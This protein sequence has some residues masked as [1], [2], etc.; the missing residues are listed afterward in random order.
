EGG[1]RA[2]V[3]PL[4]VGNEEMMLAAL[5]SQQDRS[6]ALETMLLIFEVAIPL[7]LVLCGIAGYLL[8][9]RSLAPI[10]RMTEQQRRFMAD[11]AHELRTP[12]AILRAEAGVALSN[13]ERAPEE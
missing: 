12:V 8:A 7:A 3:Q 10:A 1:Y 6:D 5:R 2:V 9:R 13:G 11:A 4:N